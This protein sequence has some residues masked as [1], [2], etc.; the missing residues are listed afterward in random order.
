MLNIKQ[1]LNHAFRHLA[2]AGLMMALMG[3]FIASPANV[4]ANDEA[5]VYGMRPEQCGYV[6]VTAVDQMTGEL[7]SG[8]TVWAVHESGSIAKFSEADAV[9]T[10]TAELRPGIWK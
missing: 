7:V 2:L 8:A 6:G 4:S 3:A 9:G 1:T 5:C 10:Y